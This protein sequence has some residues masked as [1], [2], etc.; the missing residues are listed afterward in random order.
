VGNTV[1]INNEIALLPFNTVTC[2]ILWRRG[3]DSNP[4]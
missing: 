3:R 4:R 2:A 1:G